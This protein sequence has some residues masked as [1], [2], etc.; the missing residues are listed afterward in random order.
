MAGS[1]L[2]AVLDR[3]AAKG[4]LASLGFE[5]DRSVRAKPGDRL[6]SSALASFTGNALFLTKCS[7]CAARSS[8][9]LLRRLGIKPGELLLV[10]ADAS[11][12][13]KTPE[14]YAMARRVISMEGWKAVG[15]QVTGRPALIIADSG[16]V[17]E[18]LQ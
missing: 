14:G 6:R 8:R 13:W 1:G 5:Y 3:R 12:D 2:T 17:K 15:P 18:V 11:T 9:M 7:D 16:V 4:V 10:A